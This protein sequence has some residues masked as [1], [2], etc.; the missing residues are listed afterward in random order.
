MH[1]QHLYSSNYFIL[2]VIYYLAESAGK[3]DGIDQY[4][5][6]ANNGAGLVEIILFFEGQ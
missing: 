5:N 1:P 4:I 6:Y 3:M 2:T